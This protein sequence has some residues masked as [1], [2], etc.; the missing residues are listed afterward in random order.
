MS[1]S[2]GLAVL[3]PFLLVFVF[4]VGFRLSF[5]FGLVLLFVQG[6]GGLRH[7]LYRELELELE[8]EVERYGRASINGMGEGEMRIYAYI[9]SRSSRGSVRRV[10]ITC[11]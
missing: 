2:F 11:C 9:W 1:I 6:E 7:I 5:V 4:G 3:F 8:L 10:A